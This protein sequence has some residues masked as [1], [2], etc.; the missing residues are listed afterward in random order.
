LLPGL[1][2]TP[3]EGGIVGPTFANVIGK[4]FELLK[5]GDRFWH[6]TDDPTTRF[7]RGW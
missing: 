3:V 1:S 2:E 4:Q 7:T 6:E 5:Y